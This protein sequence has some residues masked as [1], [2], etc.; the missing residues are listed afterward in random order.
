LLHQPCLQQLD[1]FSAPELAHLPKP[2]QM[3]IQL[4]ESRVKT[5]QTVRT[6]YQVAMAKTVLQ[7][8][9]GNQVYKVKRAYQ[10]SRD[11]QEKL[12][13]RVNQEPQEN[14]GNQANQARPALLALQVQ[15][16][17]LPNLPRQDL[18]MD[19]EFL[20]LAH[21]MTQLGHHFDQDL[22]E[23]FSISNP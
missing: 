9:T 18:A 15:H 10:A 19:K 3:E 5:E 12:A 1:P 22:S 2:I 17:H 20:G 14:L 21:V 13:N 4:K 7:E 16:L 8:P 6:V 23:G 11:H